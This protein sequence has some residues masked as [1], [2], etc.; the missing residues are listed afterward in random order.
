MPKGEIKNIEKLQGRKEFQLSMKHLGIPYDKYKPLEE[1]ILRRIILLDMD[2][3]GSTPNLLPVKNLIYSAANGNAV[4]T[5]FI[6]GKVVM[7]DRVIKTFDEKE[8]FRNGEEAWQK[9]VHLGGHLE[10]DPLYLK[11]SPWE[12]L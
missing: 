6:Y 2:T 7:E 10:R 8:T 4:D 5:V 9:L 3:P 1:D 11:P 12:Y